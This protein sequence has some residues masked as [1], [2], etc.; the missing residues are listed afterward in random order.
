MTSPH[1]RLL[2]QHE[3]VYV[4]LI[5]AHVPKLVDESVLTFDEEH[6]MIAPAENATQVLGRWEGWAQHS[7]ANRKLMP[8]VRWMTTNE[9]RDTESGDEPALNQETEWEQAV[10]RMY[11]PDRDGGLSTAI[12]FAIADAA[13]VSPSEV[14][15]PPLYEVVDVSGIEQAFFGMNNDGD[16]RQGTG[17]VEFR[18]TEYLIKVRSDGWVQVYEERDPERR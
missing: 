8:V 14:K 16:S 10:Q 4:S 2:N 15:S 13:D 7:T 5:H 12:V 6:E 17:T 1:M 11:E 18:Y 9:I 3:R